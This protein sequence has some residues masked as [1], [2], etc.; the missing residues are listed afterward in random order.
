M[1]VTTCGL[2]FVFRVI[3]RTP[4]SR[5]T[6]DRMRGAGDPISFSFISVSVVTF[7]SLLSLLKIICSKESNYII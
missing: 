5:E 7:Q 1:H 2:K 3:L 4:R 6:G